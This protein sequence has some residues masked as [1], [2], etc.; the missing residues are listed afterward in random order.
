MNRTL[1]SYLWKLPLCG[2][3]FF[4][5]MAINGIA[6]PVLGF[7]TPEMPAG[8]D[9]NTIALHFLL[10]SMILSLALSFVSINLRV[11]W[12]L[13]W[14]ILFE[15]TWVFGVVGM[16]IESF[17][18]MTTGAVSSILNALFTVLSF[19]LPNLFLSGAIALLFRPPGTE[20]FLHSLNTFFSSRNVSQWYWRFASAVLAYP[21]IYFTFGLIVQ[22]FIKDF[23]SQGMYEL[24]T[25][26]WGQL[27][28]L[29]LLRSF[30]FLLVSL[31]VVIWWS[32]SRRGLWLALGFSIFVLT[33]FMAVITAYWFPWE[34]RLFHGLEL[35]AD[36]LI[37]AGMLVMLL[38]REQVEGQK[39][40]ENVRRE[41]FAKRI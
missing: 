5:G 13:H 28:P 4:I 30:I 27:I 2:I 12:F 21:L 31:P 18:F 24:T 20:S 15:L 33:A 1:L 11:C 22:P 38:G 3:A 19:L 29:Q 25:P 16:V 40:A 23:Y 17:F 14:V 37:Y 9:S 36:G 10:G 41:I 8:T 39:E 34:M 7:P 32:S 26:T 35:L 6:M